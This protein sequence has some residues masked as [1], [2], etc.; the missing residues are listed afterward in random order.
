MTEVLVECPSCNQRTIKLFH[1]AGGMHVVNAGGARRLS[2][3]KE[4]YS[5]LSETC[6]NCGLTGKR[7]KDA[8]RKDGVL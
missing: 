8:L 4:Y 3:Y 1:R 2:T 7:L 5:L 6:G